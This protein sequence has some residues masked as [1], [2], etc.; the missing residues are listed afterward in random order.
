MA[1]TNEDKTAYEVEDG[2]ILDG[3]TKIEIVDDTPAVDQ[4]RTPLRDTPTEVTDEELTK[5]SDQKLKDRLSHLGKGYHEE[6]RAKEAAS[7]ERDEAVRVAQAA[8]AENQRLQGSLASN[9]NAL[10]DQAKRVVQGE[11]DDAKRE[12]KAAQE[13]FDTDAI[14]EAQEKLTSAKIKADR[15]NN[16]KPTPVHQPN[17]VV[18]TQQ[19]PQ[20]VAV[21][22]RTQAWHAENQWFGPN[23]KMTAYA[24]SLHEDLVEAGITVASD[25]Y[26]ERVNDDIRKR[27]P[28]AFAGEPAGAHPSQ[29]NRSNV[30]PASRSTASKKVVLTQTQVNLAKRLGLPL[31]VYARSVA[32]LNR[33]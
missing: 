32:E 1:D 23:R 14:V 17:P 7:R 33:N 27:F 18:Q 9:Q 21:D 29:R 2:V 10:L 28:E 25:A 16:F 22:Q 13:A 19:Q 4:G 24:L 11:I 15:V 30:A 26:Y 5:Y 3:D 20:P 8:V 6:R 31:D 12:M